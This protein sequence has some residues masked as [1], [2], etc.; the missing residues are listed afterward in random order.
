VGLGLLDERMPE[1]RTFPSLVQ[2]MDRSLEKRRNAEDL[3]DEAYDSQRDFVE[4]RRQ[5]H[6]TI[7]GTVALPPRVGWLEGKRTP[8]ACGGWWN[9]TSPQS[10]GTSKRAYVRNQ[11]T[12]LSE[13]CVRSSPCTT[14]CCPTLRWRGGGRK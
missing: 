7:V 6:L 8:S 4:V 1:M 2:G 10:K 13:G 14:S 9:R 11:R 3:A 12:S 5:L